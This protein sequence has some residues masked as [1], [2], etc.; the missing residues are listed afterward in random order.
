MNTS[1]RSLLKGGIIASMA[2]GFAAMPAIASAAEE[3]KFPPVFNTF[4]L[5]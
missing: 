2:T 5:V 1:R 3:T 4:Y